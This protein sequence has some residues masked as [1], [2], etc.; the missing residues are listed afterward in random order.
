MIYFARA[1]N[2]H[3]VKIGGTDSDDDAALADEPE[4]ADPLP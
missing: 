4:P 3:L 2:L 1:V